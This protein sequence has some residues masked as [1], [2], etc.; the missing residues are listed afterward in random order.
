MN[1]LS[2]NFVFLSAYVLELDLL[3][4]Y[5]F[6]FSSYIKQVK[7]IDKTLEES[8][9]KKLLCLDCID[10]MDILLGRLLSLQSERENNKEIQSLLKV[11]STEVKSSSCLV[12][13]ILYCNLCKIIHAN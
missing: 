3:V 4:S 13:V 9:N 12:V 10:A 5:F 8:A 11:P 6:F 2:F 7:I 1:F